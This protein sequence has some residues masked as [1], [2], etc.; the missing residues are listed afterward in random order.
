[1]IKI[2]NADHLFKRNKKA[3]LFHLLTNKQLI[4]T[5]SILKESTHIKKAKI[6]E[7]QQFIIVL[8]DR[9]QEIPTVENLAKK[10]TQQNKIRVM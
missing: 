6:K 10:Q 7:M 8:D 3:L 4:Q 5:H 9:F 1:M 2:R